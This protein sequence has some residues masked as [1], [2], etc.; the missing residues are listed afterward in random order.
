[1]LSEGAIVFDEQDE[2]S[3]VR[4]RRH[5]CSGHCSAFRR[6][7]K[8]RAYGNGRTASVAAKDRVTA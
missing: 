4:R 2:G 6:F 5:C 8:L 3:L 7:R 1:V